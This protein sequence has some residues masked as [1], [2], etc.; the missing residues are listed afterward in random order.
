M[1]THDRHRQ[2]ERHHGAARGNLAE[3]DGQRRGLADRR[4][5]RALPANRAADQADGGPHLPEEIPAQ[6]SLLL[7]QFSDFAEILRHEVRASAERRR[8]SR[9]AITEVEQ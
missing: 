5:A 6:S 3:Q 2:E 8:Q 1:P 7:A 4:A 9:P